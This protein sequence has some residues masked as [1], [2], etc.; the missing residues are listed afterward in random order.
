MGTTVSLLLGDTTAK[1]WL[2]LVGWWW[3]EGPGGR[4]NLLWAGY[5]SQM[6]IGSHIRPWH[7]V[8]SFRNK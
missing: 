3:Q 2:F 6:L 8:P 4:D 7:L 5:E 1:F